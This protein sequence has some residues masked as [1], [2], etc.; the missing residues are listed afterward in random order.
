MITFLPDHRPDVQ[1]Y[2]AYEKET[3][4]GNCTYR[5]EGYRMLFLSTDLKQYSLLISLSKVC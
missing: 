5:L 3:E 1:C 2:R 4:T